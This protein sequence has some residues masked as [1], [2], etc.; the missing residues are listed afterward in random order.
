MSRYGDDRYFN[1]GR[2]ANY[3]PRDRSRS[4]DSYSAGRS[5]G[6]PGGPFRGNGGY[7]GRGGGGGGGG[8]RG[9]GGRGGRGGGGGGGRFAPRPDRMLVKTNYFK[10]DIDDSKAEWIQY[11][12]SIFKYDKIKGE[13]NHFLKNEDGSFKR[14]LRKEILCAESTEMT[15]RILRKLSDVLRSERKI[16]LVTD[17]SASAFSNL[18]FFDGK[19]GS[20]DVDVRTDCDDDDPEAEYSGKLFAKVNLLKVGKVNPREQHVSEIEKIRQAMD[21]ICKSA[22]LSVGMKVSTHSIHCMIRTL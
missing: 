5:Q 1:R 6:G 18:P 12:V 8:G 20:F 11:K 15:R 2:D 19:E 7:G 16:E 14:E 4:R 10:I 3:P 17:G 9:F 13:D 21:I 22:L